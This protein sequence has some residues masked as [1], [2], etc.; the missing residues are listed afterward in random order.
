[1]PINSVIISIYVINGDNCIIQCVIVMDMGN[2][3]NNIELLGYNYGI[4]RVKRDIFLLLC[5]H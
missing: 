2:N 5:L 4:N 3:M 1:M